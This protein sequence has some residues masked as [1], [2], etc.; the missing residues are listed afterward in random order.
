VFDSLNKYLSAWAEL[1]VAYAATMLGFCA[2][3]MSKDDGIK[4]GINEPPTLPDALKILG[5]C[6]RYFIYRVPAERLQPVTPT[7]TAESMD[8]DDEE[9]V[10]STSTITSSHRTG[11]ATIMVKAR[12]AKASSATAGSASGKAPRSIISRNS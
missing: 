9:I 12:H 10:T 6:A 7:G 2:T 5:D 11:L 3:Q 1:D 4:K 8:I